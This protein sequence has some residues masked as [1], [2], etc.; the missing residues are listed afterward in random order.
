MYKLMQPI[1]LLCATTL[2]AIAPQ[3][4][5]A[6]IA[7]MPVEQN[8]MID[9]RVISALHDMIIT[10]LAK[11]NKFDLVERAR[12][13]L[14]IEEQALGDSG[15]VDSSTAAKIGQLE[16]AGFT[17]IAKV[18]EAGRHEK[19]N[20]ASAGNFFTKA[21]TGI[22]FDKR[23]TTLAIDAR[24]VDTTTGTI[25][26]ADTFKGSRS[27]TKVDVGGLSFDPS[28]PEDAEMARLVIGELVD[29]IAFSAY[30]PKIVKFD[31]DGQLAYLNYGEVLFDV[32]DELSIYTRGE[33]IKD[34][35]TEQIIGYEETVIGRLKVDEVR[36][37]LSTAKL[38]H[39]E[40]LVGAYCRNMT[41][42]DRAAAKSE[43]D[44][45]ESEVQGGKNPI[46]DIK[47]MFKRKKKNKE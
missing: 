47:Q 35:D 32:G 42:K 22:G 3:A 17:L 4:Q 1:V 41:A 29:R 37:S 10:E 13:D 8:G 30:P 15:A 28:D 19:S 18:T 9:S 45:E 31:T 7:V 20:S 33:P 38:I 26:F 44:G 39:G 16:G 2:I 36:D 34:I 21:V 6:K 12:L 40:A 25:E 46:K 24:F 27:K 43:N 23:K 5:K 14:V 11:T